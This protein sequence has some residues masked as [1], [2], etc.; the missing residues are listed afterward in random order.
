MH[1][2]GSTT[3]RNFLMYLEGTLLFH[4]CYASVI[5]IYYVKFM[6]GLFGFVFCKGCGCAWILVELLQMCGLALL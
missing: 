5:Y 6:F 4:A 1:L 3:L 2:E